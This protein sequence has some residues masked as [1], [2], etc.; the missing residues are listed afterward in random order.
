MH[1]VYFLQKLEMGMTETPAPLFFQLRFNKI[2]SNVPKM[3]F[4]NVVHPC[5]GLKPLT[6]MVHNF[7]VHPKVTRL[8][9]IVFAF[10][11][12]KAIK[13][14]RCPNNHKPK[15]SMLF[16]L[17]TVGMNNFM[18]YKNVLAFLLIQKSGK[19]KQTKLK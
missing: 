5:L 4:K 12:L 9:H 16:I 14:F 2:F 18:I 15:C 11:H 10:G 17:Y 6:K 3:P 7:L 8:I 1:H 19:R 13:Y